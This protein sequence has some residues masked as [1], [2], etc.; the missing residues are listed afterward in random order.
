MPYASKSPLRR[1]PS[2]VVC[3]CVPSRWPAY[4]KGNGKHARVAMFAL[5]MFISTL[6]RGLLDE[7]VTSLMTLVKLF[8]FVI[9]L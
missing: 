3:C 6:Y 5:F 2:Y 7:W 9:L 1:G 8:D 4:N